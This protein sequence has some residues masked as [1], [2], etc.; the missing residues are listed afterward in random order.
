[1]ALQQYLDGEMTG[2][3]FAATLD[4]TTDRRTTALKVLMAAAYDDPDAPE[5]VFRRLKELGFPR[6]DALTMMDTIEMSTRV[7]LFDEFRQMYS[8]TLTK[9]A[10]KSAAEIRAALELTGGNAK[11]AAQ[12][13]MDC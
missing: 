13:L 10:R 9:S 2:E 4:Q 11:A 12:F 7:D 8:T 1:M 3:E 6:A 5:V